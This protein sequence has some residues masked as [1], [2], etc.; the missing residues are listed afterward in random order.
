MQFGFSNTGVRSGAA[1]EEVRFRGGQFM[2]SGTHWLRENLALELSMRASDFEVRSGTLEPEP[3]LEPA[4]DG[5]G[6]GTAEPTAGD[7]REETR[8]EGAFGLLCGVRYYFP[9]LDG[10]VPLRPYVT[11]AL[12]P[13]TDVRVH[14]IAGQDTDVSS[15]TTR[16]GAYV[17]GGVDFLIKRRFILGAYTGTTLRR[18]KESRIGFGLTLG[19]AFGGASHGP[20]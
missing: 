6:S 18:G 13:H 3:I 9:G 4:G 5:T 2:M 10:S 11:A 12:G 15:G 17:G 20:L 14:A 8:T 19:V 16:P 1:G 7:S